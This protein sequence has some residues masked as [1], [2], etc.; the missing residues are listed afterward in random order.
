MKRLN[1]VIGTHGRFGEELVK[2][3]EMIIGAMEQVH[4]VSL[5]SSKSFEDYMN[6]AEALLSKLEG[7]TI[8]LVDLLGGTPSNVFTVLTKKYNHHVITGLNLPILITL[9]LENVNGLS[10]NIHDLVQGCLER[11]KTSVVYT[12]NQI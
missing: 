5:L 3:A 2:S 6:E 1:I 4:C 11:L 8:V 12:N 9:Y 10:D 7:P